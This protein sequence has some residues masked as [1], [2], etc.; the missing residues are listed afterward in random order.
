MARGLPVVTTNVGGNPEVV[1][2]GA[3]GF[4][5]PAASSEVLA[6]AIELLAADPTRGRQMGIAG[7]Q[8]VENNFNIRTMMAQVE[9]LY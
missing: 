9:A 1:V 5:V 7:R 8:R 6:K 2:D 4:L 3:T